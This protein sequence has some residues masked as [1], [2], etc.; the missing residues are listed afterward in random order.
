[1]WI[2]GFTAIVHIF[3]IFAIVITVATFET[4]KRNPLYFD[5]WYSKRGLGRGN[6]GEHE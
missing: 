4:A 2:F 3:L 5:K 1:M 6:G